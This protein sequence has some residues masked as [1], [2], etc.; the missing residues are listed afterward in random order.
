M[1]KQLIK[2]KVKEPFQIW[3]GSFFIENN[4]GAKA[5]ID[6]YCKIM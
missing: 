3:K 4:Y 2:D 5:D 6:F 1:P